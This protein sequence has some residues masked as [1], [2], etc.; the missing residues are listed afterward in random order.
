MVDIKKAQMTAEAQ[1]RTSVLNM[2]SAIYLKHMETGLPI[3]PELQPLIQSVMENVALS[4]VVSTDE[5]KQ[6]IQAQM[7]AAQQAQMQAA[8][9]GGQSQEQ[10][11]QQEMQGEGAE[12]EM[13]PQ[14]EGQE[15]PM[16]QEQ[17]QPIPEQ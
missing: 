6:A 8:Q 9:Q 2:A 1:N 5:Q 12:G 13:P 14:E 11:A 17:G 10:I 7:Q 3:P 16:E 15:Q 4:A